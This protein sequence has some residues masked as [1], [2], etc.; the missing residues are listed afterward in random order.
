[1]FLQSSSK[2]LTQLLRS[3]AIDHTANKSF[4]TQ[5]LAHL[6]YTRLNK[7]IYSLAS[8][9][10]SFLHISFAI[11]DIMIPAL[12]APSN[13]SLN[14]L[15]FIKFCSMLYNWSEKIFIQSF[16]SKIQYR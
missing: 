12:S 13:E 11:R 4:I 7:R 15:I 2:D 10:F 3:P 6:D 16:L 14:S 5:G 8:S 9:V 1:M